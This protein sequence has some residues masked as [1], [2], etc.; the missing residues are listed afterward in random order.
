MHARQEL[1][2]AVQA[3]AGVGR[4][5]LPAQPDSSQESFSWSDGRLVQGLVDAPRPFRSALRFADLTLLLLDDRD[6]LIDALPLEGRTLEDGFAFYEQRC[7]ALL[8]RAVALPRQGAAG[9]FHADASELADTARLYAQADEILRGLDAG[10][11][12][13]WPHHFDIAVLI[14]LG[15]ERT[16]GAGMSPGDAVH[17]DPYYY[18]T[19]WPYP[20]PETLPPLRAGAWNTRHWTGAVLAANEPRAI[21]EGFLNEAIA[22]LRTSR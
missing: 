12:R 4:A 11:V 13:C 21:I 6:T 16:I 3:A 10:T 9:P 17:P 18:V 5:L 8:G 15:G 19:P 7:S 1:H 20:A 14:T 2:R 22:I